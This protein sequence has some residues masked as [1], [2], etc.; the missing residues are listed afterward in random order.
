[1]SDEE[2]PD[3]TPEGNVYTSAAAAAPRRRGLRRKRAAL[4]VAGAVLVLA[5]GY[6]LTTVLMDDRQETRPE[7]AVLAP[8]TTVATPRMDGTG[9]SAVPGDLRASRTTR[10]AQAARRS[11]TPTPAEPA[12]TRLAPSARPATTPPETARTS[13]T[14]EQQAPV[15]VTRRVEPVRNGTV[16]VSSARAD[17]TGRGDLLLAADPGNAA[18]NGVRCTSEV[19][20][21]TDEPAA[22]RPDLLLCWRTSDRRSVVTM[23]VATRG[24]PDPGDSVDL[25]A[26]EWATLGSS[27]SAATGSTRSPR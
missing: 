26:R 1:M 2:Q 9:L 19:R 14:P 25:I 12:P 23:A 18:G 4:G 15:P 17:L 10:P 8:L 3:R 24:T 22:Y 6:L 20:F 5:G 7:P 11:P 16:R 21:S 27:G 13:A